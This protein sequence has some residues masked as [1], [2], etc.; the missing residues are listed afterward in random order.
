ME[1]A[2]IGLPVI[3]SDIPAHRE[4]L[5]GAAEFVAAHDGEALARK[6]MA[7]VAG[8]GDARQSD[9][10]APYS[11]EQHVE[12]ALSFIA[13]RFIGSR[14]AEIVMSDAP[15]HCPNT[16][17]SLVVDGKNIALRQGTGVAS[18]ARSLCRNLVE[19]GFDV[20]MLYG[21]H[22]ARNAA[23]LGDEMAFSDAPPAGRKRPSSCAT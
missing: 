13:S 18:Y 7:L 1:A 11:W 2:Q 8:Q 12:D 3:A 19:M 14:N 6:V 10:I 17:L 9:R 15:L 21:E 5:A 16:R 4:I 20:Q 22:I 23:A